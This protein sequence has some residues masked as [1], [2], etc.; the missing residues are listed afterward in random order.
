MVD[1]EK[2]IFLI[3]KTCKFCKLCFAVNRQNRFN[4]FYCS[5]AC[6]NLDHHRITFCQVCNKKFT[7]HATKKRVFCSISCSNKSRYPDRFKT[8]PKCGVKFLALNLKKENIFCSLDCFEDSGDRS[9]KKLRERNPQFVDGRFSYRKFALRELPN[10]CLWCKSAKNLEVHH[11]D[12]NRKN[13]EL[14]N[15]TILCRKCHRALHHGT[16]EFD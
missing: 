11:F 9:E 5:R 14:W 8:C 2:G 3:E 4:A 6:Y 12:E 10:E 16:L 1:N 15:L 13:G 7:H